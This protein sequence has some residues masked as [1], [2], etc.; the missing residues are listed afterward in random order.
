[1]FTTKLKLFTHLELCI[2]THQCI[3]LIREPHSCNGDDG[4]CYHGSQ[5]N[6]ESKLLSNSYSHSPLLVPGPGGCREVL[7]IY[8]VLSFPSISI[9]VFCQGHVACSYFVPRT[10][11]AYA[12]LC[13]SQLCDQQL[14][15]IVILRGPQSAL[16][17][18]IPVDCRSESR[19]K[20]SK[21]LIGEI[22]YGTGS[23][24]GS[25]PHGVGILSNA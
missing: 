15:T 9:S 5:E 7:R 19:G 12:A 17:P 24:R 22:A 20:D 8:H 21:R 23:G 1:M 10:A 14:L 13:V 11:A 6:Q 3:R 2:S 4:Q 18:A 16:V 25:A